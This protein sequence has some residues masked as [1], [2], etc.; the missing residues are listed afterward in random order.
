M[1][2]NHLYSVTV[3]LLSSSNL[4]VPGMNV[5]HKHPCRQNTCTDRIRINKSFFLKKEDWLVI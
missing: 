5:V 4:R 1:T 3:N 2:Q